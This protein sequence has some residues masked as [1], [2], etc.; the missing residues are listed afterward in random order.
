[1][2]KPKINFMFSPKGAEAESAPP[3]AP[4]LAGGVLDPGDGRGLPQATQE[5][6][7]KRQ[8]SPLAER[9]LSKAGAEVSP[10]SPPPGTAPQEA[11][12]DESAEMAAMRN[13]LAVQQRQLEQQASQ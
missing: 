7:A 4:G 1:M 9:Y 8:G 3:T 12:S 2:S 11:R 13:Q 10:S 6:A 5:E